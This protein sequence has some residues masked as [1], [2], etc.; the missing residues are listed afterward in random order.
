MFLCAE[1]EERLVFVGFPA[2]C[3]GTGT[4]KLNSLSQIEPLEFIETTENP[5][6]WLTAELHHK[7]IHPTDL[8]KVA[9]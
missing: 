7:L 6:F 8:R 4:D 9:N 2:I 5:L 3:G 1:A